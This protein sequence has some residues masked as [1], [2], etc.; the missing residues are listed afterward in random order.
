MSWAFV[1]EPQQLSL[2]SDIYNQVQNRM[3]HCLQRSDP[4]HMTMKD[5]KSRKSPTGG[6]N[7][8]VIASTEEEQ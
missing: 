2:T 8:Y 1:R 6:P 3:R 7:Q 5:T 4:R